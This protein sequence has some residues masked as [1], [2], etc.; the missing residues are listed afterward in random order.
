MTGRII[1]VH[2]YRMI[3][4]PV[5]NVAGNL[6]H[7]G[8]LIAY[9]HLGQARRRKHDAICQAVSGRPG[10]MFYRYDGLT[11]GPGVLGKWPCWTASRTV[12]AGLFFYGNC[13][14]AAH[15]LARPMRG[16]VKIWIPDTG[17]RWW[18]RLHYVCQAQ[19]GT[20]W[21]LE[22][23][24]SGLADLRRYETLVRCRAGGRWI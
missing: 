6:W 24:K 23:P 8:R 16:R 18:E 13:M 3:F 20:V 7:Y 9:G 4:M 12:F 2:L 1:L 22:K 21:A 14:D 15:F 10:R 11:D 19:D 5:F 17:P